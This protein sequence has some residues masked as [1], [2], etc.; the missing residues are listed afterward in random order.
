VLCA[1]HKNFHKVLAY[2]LHMSFDTL[3]FHFC[4][5]RGVREHL[6]GLKSC[7]CLSSMCMFL[8]NQC[9]FVLSKNFVFASSCEVEGKAME[10][11]EKGDSNHIGS[12]SKCIWSSITLLFK[13]FL[14]SN[15]EIVNYKWWWSLCVVFASSHSP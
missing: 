15:F 6:Q 3:Y 4:E 2:E 9:H 1:C 12:R 14:N 8:C 10:V 13:F 5:V 7:D 11:E